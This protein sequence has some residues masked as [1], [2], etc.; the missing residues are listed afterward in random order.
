MELKVEQRQQVRQ[1]VAFREVS[2]GQGGLWVIDGVDPHVEPDQ[3]RY[4]FWAECECPGD[5]LRDHENE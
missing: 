2:R 4:S 3:R 1:W 5:C